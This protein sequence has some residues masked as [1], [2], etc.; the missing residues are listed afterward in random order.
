M[1]SRGNKLYQKN[2]LS[3]T[4]FYLFYRG[5]IYAPK[6]IA[7]PAATS[8]SIFPVRTFFALPTVRSSLIP[9]VNRIEAYQA[10][11]EDTLLADVFARRYVDEFWLLEKQRLNRSSV[12]DLQLVIK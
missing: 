7:A 2:S 9:V 10:A 4:Y 6:W 8:F 5:N 1:S 12:N 3:C 11:A